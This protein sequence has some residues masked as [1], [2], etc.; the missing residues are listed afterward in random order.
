MDKL[1]DSTIDEEKFDRFIDGFNDKIYP[2]IVGEDGEGIRLFR[3][4]V[5]KKRDRVH[6]LNEKKRSLSSEKD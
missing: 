1:K 4:H 3:E 5:E 6:L 2:T